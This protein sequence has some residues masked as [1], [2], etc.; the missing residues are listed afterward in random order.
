MMTELQFI[1]IVFPL[2]LPLSA[3]ILG[4]IIGFILRFYDNKRRRDEE[5]TIT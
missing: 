1:F 4:V 5:K 3:V 2:I